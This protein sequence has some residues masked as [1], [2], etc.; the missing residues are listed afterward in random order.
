[1]GRTIELTAADGS[2]PGGLSRGACGGA[3][4]DSAGRAARRH[5]HGPGDLWRHAPHPRRRR[6]VR[7]GRVPRASHRPFSIA[8]N[9]MSMCR[10]S[11]F[12]RVSATCKRLNNEQG[13]PGSSQAAVERTWARAGKVGVVGYLLGRHASPL[14]RRRKPQDRCGG[15]LL[16]RRHRSMHLDEKPR[17]RS[18]AFR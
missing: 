14:W 13:S 11:D 5:R 17:S 15:R 3:P 12:K 1:M 8:W 16:W 18:V 2:S 4:Q 10:T 6:S 7:R 9:A